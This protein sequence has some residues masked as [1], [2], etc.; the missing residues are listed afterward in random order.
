MLLLRD[1]RV[2]ET[3]ESPE[4]P[5]DWIEWIDVEN[6]EY[7]FCSED[8]QRYRGQLVRSAG[9]FKSEE[10]RLAPEGPADPKNAISM[11]DRATDID[12][13]RSTFPD[14]ASLRQHLTSRCSGCVDFQEG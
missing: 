5:P 6:E 9:F 11:V 12:R 2:L 1:D 3:F 10:W 4:Q 7:A 13:H 8:G 14:L